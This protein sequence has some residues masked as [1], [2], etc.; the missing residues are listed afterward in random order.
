M[1]EPKA[2]V[3]NG[4][5]VALP[6]L[7][8]RTPDPKQRSLMVAALVL[9]LAG[10]GVS[11]YHYREFWFPD[12]EEVESDQ[13]AVS[14]PAATQIRPAPVAG[15]VTSSAARSS[16]AS[17][18]ASNSRH[19]AA[20]AKAAMNVVA[21][22]PAPAMATAT[23]TRTVLP[24]LEVEVVAGDS[25]RTIRPGNNSLRVDLQPGTP[26]QADGPVGAETA[27]SVT[28][29]A[30]ERVQISRGTTDV[31]SRPVKPDYPLLARQMKVQGSVIL[32]AL[33]GKD[34]TIQDLRVVSGPPILAA[35]AEDAVRQWHFKPH[36]QG[37]EAV[38]TQAKI[39]VNFTI[40]TN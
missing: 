22:I 39:T 36:Y 5:R 11:L 35:A 18:A 20:N 32:Q 21:D 29:N 40:S 26:A 1:F 12:T 31:V 16:A 27:A 3:P 24:P 30:A 17:P 19:R 6:E 9:L 15:K 34:G 13:P 10:L 25:H 23:T 28:S 2:L 8:A 14:T 38:E 4:E 33:I 7:Q 37:S